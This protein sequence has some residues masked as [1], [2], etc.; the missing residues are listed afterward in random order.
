MDTKGL[1]E[2]LAEVFEVQDATE[3]QRATAASLVNWYVLTKLKQ[4]VAQ[5]SH[6]AERRH[7]TVTMLATGRYNLQDAVGAVNEV[8]EAFS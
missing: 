2:R 4:Q 6:L 3:R 1:A 8:F 7:H 5:Q